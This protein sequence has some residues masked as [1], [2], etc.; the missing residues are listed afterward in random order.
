MSLKNKRI[1][2]TAGPTWVL[3][4]KVRV[5]SNIATGE[6][7]ILLAE[8]LQSR[9]ARVTLLLGAV[10]TC[11]LNKKI[12]LIRFKFFEELRRL[13][14]KELETR[15]YSIVIHSAAVSDY[16]P[17][18]TYS[19]KVRSGLDSWKLNLVPTAKIIDAIK[20]KDKSLRLVGF[21]FEP[22]TTKARLI[23]K[24]E[25]L[26]A[27]KSCDTVVANTLSKGH[28][29]A[30]IIQKDKTHGPIFTKEKLVKYLVEKL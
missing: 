24:G 18:K 2:I 25:I 23:R 20:K 28:Y 29:S 8:E 13:V 15:K 16:R 26:L 22:E 6:T 4:D 7:G 21:K 14:I 5:I 19:S 27:R 3:I 17:L 11:C 10:G 30:Y 12:R 1:L 9:G